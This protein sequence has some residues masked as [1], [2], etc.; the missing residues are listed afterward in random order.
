M[1]KEN[2]RRAADVSDEFDHKAIIQSVCACHERDEGDVSFQ[3]EPAIT[4]MNSVTR[5][6]FVK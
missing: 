5:G 1:R 3:S 6:F 2:S 4:S